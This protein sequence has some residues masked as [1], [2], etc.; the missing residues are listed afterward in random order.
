VSTAH[1][2]LPDWEDRL[3]GLIRARLDA[4]FSWREHNCMS[5][6]SEALEA[7]SGIDDWAPFRGRFSTPVGAL[8][9]IR[10]VDGVRLPIDLADR[11]WGER[12]HISGAKLG[13]PVVAMAGFPESMGPSLGVCYG[14]S[15]LFVGTADGHRGLVRVPTL[16][17]EHCYLP[18]AS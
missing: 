2:K 6:T 18:W 5:W 12:H 9:V 13:D 14:R 17:L 7:Q 8:K 3:H 4:P 1:V 10:R 16:S 15:S 11:L